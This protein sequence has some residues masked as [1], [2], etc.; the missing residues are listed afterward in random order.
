VSV[1]LYAFSAGVISTFNPCAYTLLPAILGR[2][3]AQGK[4]GVVAGLQL[5]LALSAGALCTFGALGLLVALVGLAVGSL[6]PYLAILLA[7]AFLALAAVTLSGRTFKLGLPAPSLLEGTGLRAYYLFGFA[8]GLA[9]LGCVLPMFLTVVGLGLERGVGISF[10]AL[11]LYGLGMGAL[12]LAT[13]LGKG[14]LAR[15]G[16]PLGRYLDPLGAL[17]LIAAAGYLLYLNVG[18]LA[19]DYARGLQ[20]GLAAALLALVAGL[21]GRLS[22]RPA[23]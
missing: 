9:S 8:F 13:A 22:R 23:R 19:F 11:C 14:A 2:V 4:G 1:L 6:F 17:L 12:S 16:R 5:G 10:L 18:Y 15:W 3:L 7:L 20:V 21:G